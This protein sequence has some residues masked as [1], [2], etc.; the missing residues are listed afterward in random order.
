MSCGVRN[1]VDGIPAPMPDGQGQ[2]A[3]ANLNAVARIEVLR[4]PL[5]QLY[6]NAAGGVVQVFSQDPPRDAVLHGSATAGVGSDGQRQTGVS[7]ASGTGTAGGTLDVSR[8][9]TDG[10]RDHSAAKRTQLTS[11]VVLRPSKTSTITALLSLFDQPETQ[12][13]LGVCAADRI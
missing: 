4:G 3:T 9:S 5:A 2:A 12:D 6:G 8:Y 1:L 11:K 7:L 13:P 10:Y